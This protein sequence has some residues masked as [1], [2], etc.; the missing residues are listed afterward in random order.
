[1][2]YW[3]IVL[4]INFF[5]DWGTW[6]QILH[7]AESWLGWSFGMVRWPLCHNIFLLTLV[8]W[9]EVINRSVEWDTKFG[10]ILQYWTNDVKSAGTVIQRQQRKNG[11]YDTNSRSLR[12]ALKRCMGSL[13][14][15]ENCPPT[16]PLSQH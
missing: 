11:W 5:T 15:M 16:P 7:F 4:F 13:Y 1:M 10:S 8:Q 2:I 14:F 6:I 9:T 3:F 12:S